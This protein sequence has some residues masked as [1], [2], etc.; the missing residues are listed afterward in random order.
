MKKLSKVFTLV[1][2]SCMLIG[3]SPI[4]ANENK[5]EAAVGRGTIHTVKNFTETKRIN[6]YSVT[7]QITVEITLNTVRNLIVY[8]QGSA[9][10]LSPSSFK[11]R[12]VYT[13][14]YPTGTNFGLEV[15]VTVYRT[16]TGEEGIITFRFDKNGNQIVMN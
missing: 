8:K 7:C 4:Y 12:K 9:K 16:G 3:V 14:E 10:I 13:D 5:S 1:L 2:L 15:Q 6:G 11:V